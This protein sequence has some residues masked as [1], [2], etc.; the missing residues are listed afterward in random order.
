[1]GKM[2]NFIKRQN[3]IIY[4]MPFFKALLCMFFFYLL[5]FKY[6]GLHF[7]LKHPPPPSI[8]PLFGF[9]HSSFI[10]VPLTRPFPFLPLLSPYPYPSGYFSLF[11]LPLCLIIFWLLVLLIRF[12]LKV[13]SYDYL[14]FTAWLISL[15][16]MLSSSIHAI[17][18]GYKLLLSLCCVE[19]HCVNV[20]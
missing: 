4:Y 13:R 8:L 2:S 11:F 19:F 14:S 16:I 10:H 7:P 3:I 5:L 17:A 12:H 15:S 18:N 9:V 6:S 1:M 20:P